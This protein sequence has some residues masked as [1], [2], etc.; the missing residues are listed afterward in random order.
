MIAVRRFELRA[1]RWPSALEE[2]IPAYLPSVPID[3]ECGEKLVLTFDQDGRPVLES[4]G[5]Q[6]RGYEP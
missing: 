6:H 2:L 4:C 1:G 5:K 3:Y